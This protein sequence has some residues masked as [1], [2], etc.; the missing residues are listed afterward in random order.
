M[1]IL[2]T[3]NEKTKKPQIESLHTCPSM[4]GLKRAQI[5][6][7]WLVLRLKTHACLL[8][9][10]LQSCAYSSVRTFCTVAGDKGLLP[11]I[12][13][14]LAGLHRQHDS[15]TSNL[16]IF[17]GSGHGWN[18]PAKLLGPNVH[19]ISQKLKLQNRQFLLVA[20]HILENWMQESCINGG[21]QG[22]EWGSF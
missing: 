13:I 17:N 8:L 6:N 19:M 10:H 22:Y 9:P 11:R 16:K 20:R 5:A 3:K 18:V 7:P 1:Q 4:Y 2:R 14:V 21:L 15:T 12:P